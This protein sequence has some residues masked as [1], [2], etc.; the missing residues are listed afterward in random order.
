MQI[1]RCSFKV[2]KMTKCRQNRLFAFFL[3]KRH[4]L[5]IAK[6]QAQRASGEKKRILRK[7]K[8]NSRAVMDGN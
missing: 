5:R 2:K 1:F 6:I 4:P 7:R 8:T 3:S